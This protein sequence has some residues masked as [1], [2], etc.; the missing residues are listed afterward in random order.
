MNER[1]PLPPGPDMLPADLEALDQWLR[2]DGERWRGRVP[3]NEA[4]MSQARTLEAGSGSPAST[5]AL[6]DA[7]PVVVPDFD[8]SDI[9]RPP[10][11]RRRGRFPAVLAAIAAVLI[12]ALMLAVVRGVTGS[13]NGVGAGPT[14]TVMPA[15]TTAPFTVSSV[16]LSVAPTDIA[17]ATCG[18]PATF[19]YTATFA[20]PPNTAGGTIQ[21]DYTLNNGRSQTPGTVT[22]APG[23]TSKTFTFV[24]SGALPADH[25][26]PGPAI[27]M[28][29]SPNN[30]SSPP[31]Q[32]SGAC[33]APSATATSGTP[34]A[35]GP[36]QVNSVVMSVSPTSIAG[37]TCGTY[38]TVTYTATFH[39]AANGPGGTIHFEYTVN[40]GRGSTLATLAVAPR[41]TTA[42][43]SFTW[44]GNLPS[45]HTYPE[46]GGVIVRSPTYVLP[47]TVWPTGQCS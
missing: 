42:T 36:F 43:Y 31:V 46:P 4:L 20:V 38:L 24:S 10:N 41:Q 45:D 23:E 3:S 8:A 15:A 2:N 39:L 14:A 6:R 18:S 7:P 33:V 1:D 25:T 11:T 21:F 17:G 26:Y 29:T 9:R 35:S 13:N 27:V 19:T 34:V 47:P 32:P 30:V 40:N 37:T 22:L 5:T 28:V 44:A 12:I 16:A